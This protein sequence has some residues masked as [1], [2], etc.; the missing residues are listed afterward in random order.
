MTRTDRRLSL[1]LALSL[2]TALCA[3]AD[4]PDTKKKA[5]ERAAE[6]S[7]AD[8][9]REAEAKA[10]A[11]DVN[12]AV[13]LLR[14]AAAQPGETG[15]ASLALGRLL[16]GRGELDLAIDAYAAAGEKLAGAAKGEA[17]GRMSL[18]QDL[19]G[20]PE[21]R[22]SAEAAAAADPEGVWPLL[23]LS[24]ARVHAG[25]AQ[26][27]L[28]LAR[29]A[30]AAGGGA[31]ASSAL[32][33]AYDGTGDLAAA[34][35]AYRAALA[36]P[37]HKAAATLGLARVLRRS[38][39]AAE[40]EPLL[41]QLIEELP[42]AID[43]YKE[44][45]RVKLALNR[46]AD[47]LADATL[48]ATM[49]EHDTDARRLQHEAAVAKA[50]DDAARG[51]GEFALADLQ[52]LLGDAPDSA[53]LLVGRG[54]V[55]V[56]LRQPDAALLELRQAV[57]AEPGSAEAQYWL[58]YVLHMLK[59]DAAAALPAYEK[60]VAAAPDDAGYRTQ[61]GAALLA[62]NQ[63][64]RAADELGRATA[65]PGYA[66]ADGFLY[67]GAAHLGAKRYAPAIEALDQAA[68]RTPD[69]AQVQT[70]LAWAYFG[71]KDSQ[72]FMAHARKAKALGQKDAQLLDYLAR[73]EKGEPIK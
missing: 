5:P 28:A 24:H 23:A 22:S 1:I 34:E 68:T 14:K 9:L 20:M 64:D 18:A 27:A 54:R 50:L 72:G 29:K 10:A 42:G 6:P 46:P 3:A 63:F 16:E 61:L 19:R 37:G 59:R 48:A 35:S 55:Y 58:G 62:L 52:R 38:G 53:A 32:G 69:D 17:L 60:A 25:R 43:A 49:A 31:A 26:E 7:P 36:D 70:Y 57:A 45:A 21:S 44:S 67:L 40:A 65:A 39:R 71:R 73:V 11:G 13:A 56:A 12:G 2:G 33:H 51:Q 66:R 41:A 30:E 8:A 15:A 47:A 4:K